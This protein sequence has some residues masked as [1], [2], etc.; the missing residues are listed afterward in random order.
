M[1]RLTNLHKILIIAALILAASTLLVIG[2]RQ[3]T[4][5]H[6]PEE[7]TL[8]EEK[9]SSIPE[10]LELTA[11]LDSTTPEEETIEIAIPDYLSNEKKQTKI[12]ILSQ[13]GDAIVEPQEIWFRQPMVELFGIVDLSPTEKAIKA[14]DVVGTHHFQTIFLKI[15]TEGGETHLWPIYVTD[16]GKSSFFNTRGTLLAKDLDDDGILEVAEIVDEYP[17]GGGRGHAVLS[18]VYRYNGRGEFE[19][20]TNNEEEYE[21]YFGILR[22]SMAPYDLIRLSESRGPRLEGIGNYWEMIKGNAEK[23]QFYPADH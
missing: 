22:N 11:D 16:S 2:C 5:P 23:D 8:Q 13:S 14:E 17:S 18:G 9:G 12:R 6:T 15:Y 20:L 10:I 19:D 21:K 4:S 7:V 1:L 3:P